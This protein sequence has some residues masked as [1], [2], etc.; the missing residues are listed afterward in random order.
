MYLSLSSPNRQC[1]CQVSS[2]HSE[3]QNYLPSPVVTAY[4]AFIISSTLN[5]IA[6][7]YMSMKVGAASADQMLIDLAYLVSCG[8]AYMPLIESTREAGMQFFHYFL[9]RIK[10]H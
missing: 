2:L 3:A 6:D 4:M 7:L 8:A 9:K 5:E 1:V 10:L